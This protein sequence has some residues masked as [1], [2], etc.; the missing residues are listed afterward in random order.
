MNSEIWD[1]KV[2]YIDRLEFTNKKVKEIVTILLES[3]D[4]KP[5]IIIQSDTEPLIADLN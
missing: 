3:S 1:E 4:D 2:A 5:I